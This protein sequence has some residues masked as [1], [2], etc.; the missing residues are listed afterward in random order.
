M[1]AKVLNG[2]E[3]A[4][5]I[6]NKLTS[7]ISLYTSQGYRKP[8]LSVVIIGNNKA[9]KVYISQK[10]KAAE[11]VGIDFQ[12]IEISEN[13]NNTEVI[14]EINQLNDNTQIDGIIVQLPIPNNLNQSLILNA[15]APEKDVD[16]LTATNFGK[17]ALG[18][19]TFAPCTPQACIEI[20][21][22]YNIQISGKKAVIV[23]RSNI[24]GKPLALMLLNENATITI[25]HSKTQ[26]LVEVT[27][28]ADIL[29]TAIGKSNFFDDNYVKEGAV[30]VDVGIN[31]IDVFDTVLQ[32]YIQKVTGD[33]NYD[34][35]LNKVSYI[36]PVP[37]GVGP[38]TVSMLLMNTLKAYKRNLNICK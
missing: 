7:E 3:L 28:Q 5:N 37:G 34:A 36:T 6:K 30:V 32:K 25:A 27:K 35:V 26:N 4:S 24:V 38:V 13:A 19:D 9:S 1:V 16:C 29:F 23:G 8:K 20:L 10:K 22:A 12:L 31:T 33:V 2:T 21:K 18:E 17:L 14:Q 15:I 11:N